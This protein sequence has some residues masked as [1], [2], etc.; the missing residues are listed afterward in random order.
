MNAAVEPD[1][2]LGVAFREAV[3]RGYRNGLDFYV[4]GFDTAFSSELVIL[5]R[6]PEGG[7][8]VVY[9]DMGRENLRAT[10]DRVEDVVDEFFHALSTVAWGRGRGPRPEPRRLDPAEVA[11]DPRSTTDDAVWAQFRERASRGTAV[12]P[13][14]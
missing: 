10:G 13:P 11:P 2:A 4:E 5:E 6:A 14:V 8:R 12:R 7:C 1:P 9:S 3:S